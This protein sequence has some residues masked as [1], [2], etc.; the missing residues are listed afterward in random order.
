MKKLT[1]I[2]LILTLYSCGATVR[3]LGGVTE[4]KLRKQISIEQNCPI[5]QIKILKKLKSV[6]NATYEVE[7]CGKKYI[8]KQYGSIFIESSQADQLLKKK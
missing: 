1:I 8:Y 2:V 7:A 5:D 4:K 6:G 3:T